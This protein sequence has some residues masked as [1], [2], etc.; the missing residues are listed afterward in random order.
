M[1]DVR[2]ALREPIKEAGR[3]VDDDV[4]Q[5]MESGTAGYPF[6][7]QLVGSYVWREH[8][9]ERAISME[10]ALSGVEAAHRRMGALVHEPSLVGTTEVA[11]TFLVQMAKDDGPSRMADIKERMGVDDNYASQYRLRLI[12]HELIRPVGHGRVDFAIPYLREYLNEHA[13]NEI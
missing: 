4:L 8:P 3:L 10:D 12:A 7:I 11:R 5:I 13:T 6:L 9:N 1:T 2:R